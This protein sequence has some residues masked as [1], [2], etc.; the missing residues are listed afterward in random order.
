MKVKIKPFYTVV[1]LYVFANSLFLVLG[2]LNNNLINM[3][4]STF[5]VVTNTLL[6]AFFLQLLALSFIIFIYSCFKNKKF[7]EDYFC[8]KI[9]GFFL[10]FWQFLFLMFAI[11]LGVGV[12]GDNNKSNQFLVRLSN[13]ISAD[14]LY[15]LISPSLRSNKLFVLNTIL[16]LIS[17]IVRGWLGGIIIAF[18]TYLCRVGGLKVNL[19]LLFYCFVFFLILLL[20]SPFLID[21]KF[22]IRSGKNFE[23][24][25]KTKSD[26]LE[27]A[28][29]Y[30]LG[31]FQHLGHTALLIEHAD[32]YRELYKE[33]KILPYW[34]EG[35]LQNFI[36]KFLGNQ[37][38]LT[39]S[40][41]MAVR[42]FGAYT[43][44]AWNANTGLSGWFVLLQEK[45][46]VLLI[47]WGVLIFSFFSF[48]YKY[49]NRQL[50]NIIS[51]F[52]VIYLYHGWFGAFFNLMML[53]FL[54]VFFN[55]LV[56]GRKYHVSN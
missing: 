44:E 43:S 26:K 30:L 50:F 4:F 39:Y 56:L 9:N 29:D 34:L 11:F 46:I 5:Y 24:D 25:L 49:A 17:S 52:M 33:N 18:F 27:I 23:F 10:F 16:Y 13:F 28:L 12:V 14:I 51:V 2:L 47:Y 8:G 41:M 20:L 7:N 48:L 45:S 19:R 3:E 36:Y 37:E 32:S 42:D 38:L 15:I 35:I 1:I 21:L 53:A 6:Y 22:N 40:N 31:R 55:K 54:V